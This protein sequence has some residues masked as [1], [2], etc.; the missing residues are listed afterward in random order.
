MT[1][2]EKEKLRRGVM[3]G[4]EIVGAIGVARIIRYI[5]PP[6]QGPF[7]TAACYVAGTLIASAS[8]DVFDK[9]LLKY[10]QVLQSIGEGEKMVVF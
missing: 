7:G 2:S 5:T 8:M 3:T 1:I 9:Q 10:E 4:I 6:C